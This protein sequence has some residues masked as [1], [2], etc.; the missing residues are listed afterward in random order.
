MVVEVY[1][2]PECGDYYGVSGMPDLTVVNQHTHGINFEPIPKE[3]H[4]SRAQCP[5]CRSVGKS[6]ERMLVGFEMNL[7]DLRSAPA[8]AA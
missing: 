4:H 7:A 3:S 6:V 8:D 2:C 1:I 5:A